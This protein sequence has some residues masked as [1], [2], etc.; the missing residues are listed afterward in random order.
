MFSRLTPVFAAVALAASSVQ[1]AA[2]SLAPAGIVHVQN[3]RGRGLARDA[4]DRGY[5]EGLRQGQFDARRGLAADFSRD[6]VYRDAGLGYQRRFGARDSYREDFRSGY[7]DGYRQSYA[8]LRGA[9]SAPR[10]EPDNAQSRPGTSGYQEPAYA[11]GYSD[12]FRQ[13]QSDGR[14]GDRYDPIG[15]RDYRDGDQ[16]YYGSYGSRDA[17]K[18]NYRAGYREGYEEGYRTATGRR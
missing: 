12:G 11:R 9:R 14:D 8:Q 13:G 18:N 15:H 2:Q 6:P 16:G 1:C 4:Y 3:G 5:R 17:Y 7:V 10:L